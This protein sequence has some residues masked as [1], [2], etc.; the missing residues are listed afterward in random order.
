MGEVDDQLSQQG[1]V[2]SQI[3]S[4]FLCQCKTGDATEPNDLVQKLKATDYQ[5]AF[6]LFVV[7]LSC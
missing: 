6:P 2:E 7:F 1:L 3:V 5:I 4:K